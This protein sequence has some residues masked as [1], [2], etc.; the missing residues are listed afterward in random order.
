M[1]EEVTNKSVTI[2]HHGGAWVAFVDKTEFL[3]FVRLKKLSGIGRDYLDNIWRGMVEGGNGG[4][5][6]IVISAPTV[7]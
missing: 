7:E 5:E 1:T 2:G 3:F 4:G 6:L